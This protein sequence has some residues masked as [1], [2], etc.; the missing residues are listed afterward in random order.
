MELK[1]D[2]KIKLAFLLNHAKEYPDL[3]EYIET[4]FELCDSESEGEL[5]GFLGSNMRLGTNLLE[6]VKL[7]LGEEHDIS[8]MSEMVSAISMDLVKDYCLML[9][10]YDLYEED[11]SSGVLIQHSVEAALNLES[12]C[13]LH[14]REVG[15]AQFMIALLHNIGRYFLLSH[16]PDE[17]EKFL[18]ITDLDTLFRQERH[19]FG[20]DYQELGARVLEQW[21]FPDNMIKDIQ[22]RHLAI[23]DMSLVD[24]SLAITYRSLEDL[25]N[26]PEL[27][28]YSSMKEKNKGLTQKILHSID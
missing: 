4:I 2:P 11:D 9:Y 18:E 17:Y 7:K 13:E 3:P 20:R 15:E 14:N 8:S 12:L 21:N 24:L 16:L 28:K 10:L 22:G 5:T 26:H 19:L 27:H 1:L 25:L 6:I 23:D